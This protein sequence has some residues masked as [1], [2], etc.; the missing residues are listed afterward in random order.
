[1][2]K[3]PD[4]YV[5][6]ALFE[7]L[8]DGTLLNK[9]KRARKTVVGAVAGTLTVQGYIAVTVG[10]KKYR[11]HRIVWLLST[12]QWPSQH[13][14]H[15]NGVTTDNRIENL[16]D[17]DRTTNQQNQ[18]RLCKTNKTGF[19]GVFFL[20]RTGRYKAS[21]RVPGR[22]KTTHL[23]YFDTPQEAFAV[24]EAYRENHYTGYA[25]HRELT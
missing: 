22:D 16:R 6:D 2:Q 18:V 19:R 8:P 14:D 10:T 21:A 25:S 13:I 5:F 4:F 15:I 7:L 3:H 17:V 12:G 9:A 24:A 1:M 11:A 20:A 23:G